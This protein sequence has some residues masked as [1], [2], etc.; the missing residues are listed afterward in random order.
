MASHLHH[1]GEFER[2]CSARGLQALPAH[3]WAVASYLR[4]V[5]RHK[6]AALAHEVLEVISRQ[7]VLKS[8]RVPTRHITVK[9]TMET[10]DRR[11]LVRAQHA[12]LF[13]EGTHLDEISTPTKAK[14]KAV[15]KRQ[16]LSTK[17]RMVKR[18]PKS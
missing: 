5:D 4:W 13:D 18:R 6:D 15:P 8:G 14:V 3:P 16:T 1:W 17:P 12:D 11:A 10:I 7:H 2:W 9:K